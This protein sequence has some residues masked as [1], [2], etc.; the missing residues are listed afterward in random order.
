LPACPRDPL[1]ASPPPPAAART[2]AH[3]APPAAAAFQANLTLCLLGAA[4]VATYSLESLAPTLDYVGRDIM[5]GVQFAHLL[6]TA[7]YGLRADWLLAA[8][9]ANLAALTRFWRIEDPQSVIF[10]EVRGARAC[11]ACS[12]GA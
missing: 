11:P 3:S 10:D 7:A 12:C 1:A 9:L 2:A 4:L 5:L 8:L 6:A